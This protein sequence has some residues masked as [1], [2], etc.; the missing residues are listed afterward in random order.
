MTQPHCPECKTAGLD[1]IVSSPS[2]E[3]TKSGDAWFDVAYCKSC[4]HVYGVFTKRVTAMQTEA[5]KE[6]LGKIALIATGKDDD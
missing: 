4:G 1:N 3:T 6:Y 5:F 2:N